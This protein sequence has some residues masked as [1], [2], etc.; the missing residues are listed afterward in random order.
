MELFKANAQWSSRPADERFTSVDQLYQVTKSYADTAGEKAAPWGDL[1]TEAIDGDVQ[2]VGRVNVPAKL[3]NWAFGQLAA[4][5]E[6]PAEYLRKLPA[7]LAVQNLNHGLKERGADGSAQLL[8]HQ[9]G[10]LLCRAITSDRYSR[11]WNY[12]VAERLQGLAAMGWEPATPDIR[13]DGDLS[14]PKNF[15][16]YASD[17][18]LFAFLRNP[19]LAIEEKGQ[20]AVYRGVIVENSEVG[21]AAL[22]LTRF[23][24]REMCGNHIIWGASKVVDLSLRHVGRIRDQ[25]Y[26]WSYEIR[27]YAEESVSDEAAKISSAR[28]VQIA[29]TKEDV[30]DKLFGLRSLQL[31]RKTLEAGYDAVKPDQ[32]GDPRTVWGIVQGL[33]RHSQTLPY[34]DKRNDIDRAAGRVLAINF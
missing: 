17:H 22:K 26:K 14:N 31:S 18:D 13:G 11:I 27:K 3:T 1:R 21:A 25:W 5:V 10:G 12:E 30:L 33:T 9:N 34:Q 29:G 6:A 16:L 15:A 2:L 32:D 24:Y 28:T 20:G 7:T 19:N 23:L 8:F 4:R